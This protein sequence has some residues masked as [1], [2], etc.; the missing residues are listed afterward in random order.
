M[1]F[2]SLYGPFGC[3]DTV[4]VGLNQLKANLY[5]FEVRF[6]C[7]GCNIVDDVEFWFEPTLGKVFYLHFES[8][9]QRFIFCILD[10]QGEDGVAHLVVDDEYGHHAVN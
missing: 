10:G 1:V 3:V 6:Y 8:A 7:L 2:E 4:V 9:N 5:F